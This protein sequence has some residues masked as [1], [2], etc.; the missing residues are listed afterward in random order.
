[1]ELGTRAEPPNVFAQSGVGGVVVLGMMDIVR[2]ARSV[3]K[4]GLDVAPP[5]NTH[6]S[7]AD[8]VS[9]FEVLDQHLPEELQPVARVMLECFLKVIEG[10]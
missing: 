9:A 5:S 3:L 8:R 1:V 7:L 10:F 6:P 2:R 4:T